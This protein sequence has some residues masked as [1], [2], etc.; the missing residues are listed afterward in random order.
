M[1]YFKVYFDAL[2]LRP[3]NDV[4][5]VL[6]HVFPDYDHRALVHHHHLSYITHLILLLVDSYL[7]TAPPV[8]PPP[9]LQHPLHLVIQPQPALAIPNHGIHLEFL[10]GG[11]TLNDQA[12]EGVQ[13]E[14]CVGVRGQE[15]G[16]GGGGEGVEGAV[17]GGLGGDVGVDQQVDRLGVEAW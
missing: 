12:I 13:V 14:V 7:V 6:L 5:L 8:L 10:E 16:A 17:E 4:H 15:E 3:P 2:H 11:D 1:H 9:H